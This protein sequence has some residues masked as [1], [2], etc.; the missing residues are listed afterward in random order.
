LVTGFIDDTGHETFAGTHQYFGLGGCA[1]LGCRYEWL[2]TQWREV[3]RLING[4]PEKPLHA[5]DMSWRGDRS[6]SV[7]S[8]FFRDRSFVRI[9]A[10]STRQ[11]VRPTAMHPAEPVMG[12]LHEHVV[13]VAERIQCAAVAIIVESS[14]RADAMLKKYF[15]ALKLD[16]REL[17]LPVK[18]WLMPKSA[19]E[20][21]LEVA[22]FIINASGN[23]T[24]RYLA[25]KPGIS[26]DFQDV[27]GQ[28]PHYGCRFSIATK[29]KVG[30]DG[31]VR[32]EGT[33]FQSGVI[34]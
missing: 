17:I 20:P 7:L 22:D 24:R 8:Q 14:Q 13:S 31:R 21:V 28:L 32:V 29:V 16:N 33:R 2:K 11:T 18:H 9:A 15:N 4:D 30:D 1:V 23:Q 25:R 26:R 6:F 5:A 12:G 27:F 3:R 19:A 10:F 34:N